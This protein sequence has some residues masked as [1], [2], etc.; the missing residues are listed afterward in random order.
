MDDIFIASKSLIALMV[1]LKQK[2]LVA[3]SLF[4]QAKEGQDSYMPQNL[5]DMEL[6]LFFSKK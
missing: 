5:W 1:N 4:E 2:F 3:A 6:V